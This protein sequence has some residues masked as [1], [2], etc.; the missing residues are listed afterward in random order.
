MKEK[1]GRAG[2]RSIEPCKKRGK[3]GDPQHIK[4]INKLGYNNVSNRVRER[5]HRER[6]E[7]IER[8]R[9]KSLPGR[10]ELEGS[11]E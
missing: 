7:S 9:E 5:E 4:H 1:R 2:E 3:A 10:L 6:E 8:E 11:L